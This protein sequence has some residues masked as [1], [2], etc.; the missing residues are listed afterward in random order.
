MDPWVRKIPWRREWQ[1]TPVVLPGE[2]HGQRSLEGYSPWGR[3]ELNTTDQLTFSLSL[4][5][6]FTNKMTESF[7]SIE[8]R[9]RL[10]CALGH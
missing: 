3:K 8:M 4:F 9:V 5:I 1:P 10:V 7:Q 2:S 6:F